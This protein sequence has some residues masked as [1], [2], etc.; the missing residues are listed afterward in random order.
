MGS[1]RTIHGFHNEYLL[2]PDAN[3]LAKLTRTAI[4]D[5]DVDSVPDPIKWVLPVGGYYRWGRTGKGPLPFSSL[6][7]R[8]ALMKWLFALFLKITLPVNRDGFPFHELILSPLNATLIFR[9]LIHLQH[10]GYPC[11]W[12]SDFLDC[13]LS[14]NVLTSARP[15]RTSPLAIAETKKDKPVKRISVAPF[16]PEMIALTLMFE[17]ILPF[18]VM[19]KDL[20]PPS[21]VHKYTLT[22]PRSKRGLP[23]LAF[24]RQGWILVFHNTTLW[25]FFDDDDDAFSYFDLRGLLDGSWDSKMNPIEAED[26][27]KFRD[28]GLVM[29]S[30]LKYDAKAQEA[31]IWMV[32]DHMNAMLRDGDWMCGLWSTET[33]KSCDAVKVYEGG[34]RGV[35]KVKRWFDE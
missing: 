14:N 26:V 28:K 27:Y 23:P 22:V 5:Q 19:T 20:P 13:I 8:A 35:K 7:P 29:V 16:I 6:L 24:D 4:I 21:A 11:H 15:P 3:T 31:T 10:L 34:A 30:T 33:W 18:A 12:L 17:P 9:I 2:A 25:E 1:W 32:Q